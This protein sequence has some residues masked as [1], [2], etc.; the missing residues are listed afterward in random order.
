MQLKKNYYWALILVTVFCLVSVINPP[1][2][3]ASSY[4]IATASSTYQTRLYIVDSG[5]PGPTVMVVGGV[6]GNETAGYKAAGLVKD[7]TVKKGRLIVLP[8]ANKSAIARHSRLSSNGDNLNR[9][10]PQGSSETADSYIAREIYQ[11]V[12]DYGV[13]YLVDLHEGY[14]YYKSSSSSVGQTIIYYPRN[15]AKTV[16]YRMA[17][18]LN[19]SISSSYRQFTV[20]RYP[21]AGSLARASGQFL[22]V[23][24]FIFETSQKQDL[25]TR[26]NQQLKAVNTLLYY[27]GMK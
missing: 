25:D 21:V 23:T 4:N 5:V 8:E 1:A 6:H 15:D 17:S 3:A 27:L 9:D 14:D 18:N 10:F 26:I 19:S 11:V 12:K 7:F 13:D 2:Q 16:A 22:G 20:L 24:S